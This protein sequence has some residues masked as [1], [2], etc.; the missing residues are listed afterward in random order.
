MLPGR[1]RRVSSLKEADIVIWFFGGSTMEDI[2]VSAGDSIANTAIKRLNDAGLKVRGYNLGVNCFQSSNE[3]IKFSD[4][5]RRMPAEQLPDYAVFYDGYNECSCGLHGWRG[6]LWIL[7]RS[8]Q[9]R[10]LIVPENLRTLVNSF[11]SLCGMNIS[12]VC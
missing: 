10:A 4:L 11:L 5:L 12:L 2:Y 7:G 6:V 9:L 8:A 3:I 1:C